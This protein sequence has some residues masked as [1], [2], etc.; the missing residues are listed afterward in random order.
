[1]SDSDKEKNKNNP[2]DTK[3]EVEIKKSDPEAGESEETKP[4]EIQADKKEESAPAELTPEQQIEKLE[5]ELKEQEDRYLRLVAEFDNYKKRNARLFEAMV[6]SA[7]ENIIVPILEVVDNYE[8]ALESSEKADLESLRKGTELIHN[9]LK[10]LLAREGIEQI[11]AVG[12][13]FDPNLHE[14]MMQVESDKYDEGTIVQEM[15]R[16][17]K[18]KDKVI[19][20]AKVTVSKGPSDSSD[21][22]DKK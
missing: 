20:F 3:V 1:M 11:K 10:D 19:R 7:K 21:T 5:A 17:Y 9:Q 22:S 6:Q 12:E 16:G 18:L 14:A 8:R 2:D 15:V 13:P 4:E